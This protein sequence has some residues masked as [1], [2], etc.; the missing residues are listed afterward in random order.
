MHVIAIVRVDVVSKGFVARLSA[1]KIETVV[2]DGFVMKVLV[3]KEPVVLKMVIALMAPFAKDSRAYLVSAVTT[4]TVVC[5]RS[6]SR[7]VVNV[8]SVV[9][10]MIVLQVLDVTLV[11]A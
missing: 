1:Q 8:Q 11:G 6:V 9:V 3:S 2:L 10:T 7:V 5:V 4:S